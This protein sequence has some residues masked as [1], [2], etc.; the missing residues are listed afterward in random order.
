MSEL[1]ATVL[2]P[3]T[4][5]R[6]PLLPF[7]IGS[8]QNQ[9]VK[10]IEI[11]IIGDGV[12]DHS[13]SIINN[14]TEE[15]KRIKFFDNPK[16]ISRG[17]IYRHQAL[18]QARGKIIVYLLD[19]DLMLP[20]HVENL[21]KYFEKYN[22]VSVSSYL[23]RNNFIDNSKKHLGER[24]DDFKYIINSLKKK[25]NKLQ[26]DPNIHTK[27]SYNIQKM[28]LSGIG[29]FLSCI[30]HSLELYNKLPYGWRTTP[31]G[32]YTDEYMELQI[33]SD[34]N[35]KPHFSIKPS[36]ILYFKRGD[37]PG[38]PVEKRVELL[39]SWYGLIQDGKYQKRINRLILKGHIIKMMK[40]NFEKL[41]QTKKQI[42]KLFK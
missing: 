38:W 22:F 5:D 32:Y 36:S 24:D 7:S 40:K 13:R 26:F 33:F 42:Y 12:D 41:S 4:G 14:L 30:S 8:I 21:L 11:F 3:T 31:P 35:C 34:P 17:E 2:V 29:I 27:E 25:E 23:I 18:Q 19:R 9:T 1:K 28:H 39:K 15:D 16:D 10:D 37:H 20:Y 6:G